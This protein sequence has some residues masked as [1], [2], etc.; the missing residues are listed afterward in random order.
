M[1]EAKFKKWV[2]GGL[3]WVLGGPIGGLLGFLLGSLLDNV[4]LDAIYKEI[5]EG[6]ATTGEGDF[7]ISLLILSAAIIKADGKVLQSELEYVRTFFVSRFGVEKANE[8]M[9]IFNK[10]NKQEI[11]VEKISKQ[12]KIFMDY[13]SRLQLLHYLFGV[14]QADGS[15]AQP[16]MNLIER[17]AGYLDIHNRDFTSIKSMFYKST[18]NAYK[19]LGVEKSD[20]ITHIKKVFRKLTLQYHPDKVEHL[21]ADIKKSAK[22]KYLKIVEAYE[23]IKK[24]R[25]FN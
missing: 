24:E 13:P 12:I 14:A 19:I 10:L 5:R 4:D 1:T 3:G 7:R 6:S 15:I 18:D 25:D 23:Q 22:E 21:G 16:E 20:S 11:S 9:R 17:I 8:S 2:G